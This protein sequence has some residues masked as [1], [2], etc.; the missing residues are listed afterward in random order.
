MAGRLS[1]VSLQRKSVEICQIAKQFI[2]VNLSSS[3]EKSV[4]SVSSVDKKKQMSVA[5]KIRVQ[6]HPYGR[7]SGTI[8]DSRFTKKGEANKI[9]SRIGNI[10]PIPAGS[11]V[12]RKLLLQ[13][14]RKTKISFLSQ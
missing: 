2:C 4:S 13:V 6:N 8:H 9:E 12:Y 1:E 7:P 3:P 5:N 10:P 11:F 14:E